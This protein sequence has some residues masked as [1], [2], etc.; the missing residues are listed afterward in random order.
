MRGSD[1]DVSKIQW[2]N[3]H[4][5]KFNGSH[6]TTLNSMSE[7]ASMNVKKTAKVFWKKDADATKDS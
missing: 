5:K 6:E 2:R 3:D 7:A 4:A 1:E